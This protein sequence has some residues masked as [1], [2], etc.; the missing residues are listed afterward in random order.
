LH[1]G[2]AA[3]APVAV[4][5]DYPVLAFE[6]RGDGA[7]RYARRVF[8]VITPEDGKESPRVRV[9]SL[10]YV[11]HPG[12]KRA[13]RDLVFGFTRDRARVTPDAFAMVY[14]KPVF[15]IMSV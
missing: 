14:Y 1:T 7:D 8:A 9:F 12:A 15:H 11:F 6:Q 10:L 3:D 13:E 4:E 2:F 5:I